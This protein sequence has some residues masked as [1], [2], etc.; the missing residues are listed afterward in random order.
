MA[1][2]SPKRVAVDV[3]VA[4][5]IKLPCGYELIH[6]PHSGDCEWDAIIAVHP[7]TK[8]QLVDAGGPIFE[9]FRPIIGES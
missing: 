8:E 5:A 9:R 1:N 7:D 2:P 3:V 6:Q 4:R